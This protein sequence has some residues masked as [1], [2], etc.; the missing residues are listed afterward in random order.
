MI[1]QEHIPCNLQIVNRAWVSRA[2]A[3]SKSSEACTYGLHPHV[4]NFSGEIIHFPSKPVKILVMVE[5]ASFFV[6][7][8]PCRGNVKR[9]RPV[10][11]TSSGAEVE[12]AALFP[13]DR[14]CQGGA[15][16]LSSLISFGGKPGQSSHFEVVEHTET[17]EHM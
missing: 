13:F 6:N 4:A 14:Q 2:A 12:A 9:Y 1:S 15:N 5:L 3:V 11:L 10:Q 16:S 17:I 7:Y 8:V